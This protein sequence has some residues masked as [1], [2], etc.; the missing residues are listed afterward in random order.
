MSSPA[1]LTPAP[2]AG[3]VEGRSAAAGPILVARGLGRHFGGG[4]ARID[5]LR[6][7][8]LE[9]REGE[10]VA[11]MGRSGSGKSTLLHLL[12][13][14][15]EP[16]A[17]EVL[18]DG[19]DM[20]ARTGGAVRPAAELRDRIR[21]STLH[22]LL[23]HAA[24]FVALALPFAA[25]AWLCVALPAPAGVLATVLLA[26]LLTSIGGMVLTP[27]AL[28]QIVERR[29]NR[30]R[31][32]TFG[33]IFQFYHLLPDLSAL[34]NVVLTRMV[35]VPLHRW[36]AERRRAY[37]TAVELLGRVG[38]GERLSHRPG[39]LSGGERQRVAIARALVHRPRV[40]LADEPTGNLDYEAGENVLQILSQLHRDGQT[41]VMVTHDP[42]VARHAD[43]ILFL[44]DGK[45]RPAISAD[46]SR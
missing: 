12:G 23:I 4:R 18:V 44:E 25:A 22:A 42:A 26:G 31:R 2:L 43:R 1:A 6:E 9:V 38:L 8:A 20:H 37:A 10:F 32:D 14:L 19:L 16:D 45:L 40:L 27:L 24:A 39:Q 13:A 7:C 35:G 17:G 46:L 3:S 15:D 36:P 28:S 34:Q 11:I 33:F 5:V 21:R 30:L 29:R 41:I